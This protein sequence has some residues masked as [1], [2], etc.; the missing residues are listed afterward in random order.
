MVADHPLL[1]QF[2]ALLIADWASGKN[3]RN[4]T[5]GVKRLQ[6][7][8]LSGCHSLQSASSPLRLVS[9]SPF[10]ARNSQSTP[11]LKVQIPSFV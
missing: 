11:A 5:L 6:A 10:A 9:L 2:R 8:T 1:M 4:R 7:F 3:C